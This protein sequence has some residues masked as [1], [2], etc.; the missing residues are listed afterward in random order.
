MAIL[1]FNFPSEYCPCYVPNLVPALFHSPPDYGANPFSGER[2]RLQ[3]LTLGSVFHLL[4]PLAHHPGNRRLLDLCLPQ[5]RIFE[6][7]STD[8]TQEEF[9]MGLLRSV[10]PNANDAF[11][12]QSYISLT[13][14]GGLYAGWDDLHRCWYYCTWCHLHGA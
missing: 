10:L 14:F 13:T 9:T 3:G 8:L 5:V 12:P 6:L 4:E 11:Y 7:S 1:T 2:L